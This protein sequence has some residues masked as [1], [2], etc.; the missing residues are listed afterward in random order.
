MLRKLENE[1]LDK[2]KNKKETKKWIAER[3]NYIPFM[4]ILIT[5]KHQGTHCLIKKFSMKLVFKSPPI[6]I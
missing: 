5:K 1:C 4:R 2:N 6:T 3:V